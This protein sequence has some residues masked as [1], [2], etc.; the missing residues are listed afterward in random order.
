MVRLFISETGDAIGFRQQL[1]TTSFEAFELEIMVNYP[2]HTWMENAS[3]TQNLTVWSVHFGLSSRLT[4]RSCTF[5]MFSSLHTEQSLLQP[6]CRTVVPVLR[7]LFSR[8]WMLPTSKF[9]TLLEKFTQQPSCTIP[10]WQHNFW[11]QSHH[12]VKLSWFYLIFTDI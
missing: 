12:W 2:V 1:S 9:P 6:G 5:S 3:F 4:M 7:I 8:L 11:S 10:L